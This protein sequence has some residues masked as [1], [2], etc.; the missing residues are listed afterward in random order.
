MFAGG[1]QE[2]SKTAA[3]ASGDLSPWGNC[4]S[5]VEGLQQDC[6]TYPYV[7]VCD[8]SEATKEMLQR[9]QKAGINLSNMDHHW[10]GMLHG[11]MFAGKKSKESK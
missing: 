9:A 10:K 5:S 3:A 1:R 6:C 2:H 8:H 7:V 11:T 4:N